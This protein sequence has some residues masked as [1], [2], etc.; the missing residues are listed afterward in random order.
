MWLSGSVVRPGSQARFSKMPPR[1]VAAPGRYR[2][3]QPNE[4]VLILVLFLL[5]ILVLFYFS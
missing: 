1:R 4:A 5:L 2:R 3:R